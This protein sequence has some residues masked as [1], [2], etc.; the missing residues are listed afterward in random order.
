MR[1]NVDDFSKQGVQPQMTASKEMGL[2]SYSCKELNSV[3]ILN[4][5]GNIFFPRSSRSTQ[6]SQH[7]DFS[8]V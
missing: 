2:Q 4:E 6:T 1:R 7:P 5:L 8:F 3:N